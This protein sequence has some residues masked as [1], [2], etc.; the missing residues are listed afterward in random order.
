M[1]VYDE[2]KARVIEL[3]RTTRELSE[4]VRQL[5]GLLLEVADLRR[6]QA[7][8]RKV[9]GTIIA[10]GLAALFTV[11]VLT[12]LFLLNRVND[13]I[14]ERRDS[15]RSACT[16]RNQERDDLR[17]RFST[18]AQTA[19]ENTDVWAELARAYPPSAVDCKDI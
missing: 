16:A 5:S 4:S 9:A 12:S 10:G 14:A 8:T 13:L 7:R 2:D 6:A 15:V 11:A 1:P 3:E 18:L 17:E 19:K